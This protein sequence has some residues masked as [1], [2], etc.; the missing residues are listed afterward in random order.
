MKCIMADIKE[1]TVVRQSVMSSVC[2]YASYETFLFFNTTFFIIISPWG[3]CQTLTTECNDGKLLG[4]KESWLFLF[5]NCCTTQFCM[6]R[7]HLYNT[8]VTDRATEY[9]KVEFLPTVGEGRKKYKSKFL[10]TIV[11]P[12]SLLLFSKRKCNEIKCFCKRVR[13]Y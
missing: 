4:K 2:Y 5:W 12:V 10:L 1:H 7:T 13:C 9:H 3:T 6:R 11:M 8:D